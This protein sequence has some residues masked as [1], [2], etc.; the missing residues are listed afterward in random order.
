MTASA[1]QWISAPLLLGLLLVGCLASFG[2]AMRRF[3]VQPAGLTPGMRLIKV[4]GIVFG[5]LHLTAIAATPDVN[6]VRGI[7]GAALYVAALGLFWWAIKTNLHQPLS[8]AF[9][10]DL[11]AH[12]TAHGPYRMIRHPLYCSYL[13]CWLAGWVATG[14]WWLAPTIAIMIVLYM[15]AAAEEERKFARSALAQAYLEYRARTGLLLPNPWK[16]LSSRRKRSWE[17]AV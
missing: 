14:R 16:L 8:A 7:S 4:C 5:L 2:W 9:S 10:P 17:T 15:R 11:P 1:W 13:M 12:L 3:F 6:G